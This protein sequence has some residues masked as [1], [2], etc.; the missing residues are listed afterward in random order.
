MFR[1]LFDAADFGKLTSFFSLQYL[2]LFLPAV[3]LFYSLTP[4]RGKKYTLLLASLVF[5]FLI[6]RRF[7]VY[8]LATI[9][10]VWLFGLWLARLHARRDAEVKAAE[11]PQRKAIKRVWLIRSRFVLGL[12]AVFH[13][14]LLLTLKYSGFFVENVN[15]FFGLQFPVP[16]FVIPIG[17]SFFTLQAVSYLFD[18]YRGTLEADRNLLRLALFISFFPQIVEGPIC[19]YSQTAQQLWE[20]KPI[21]WENLTLGLQRI[22]Y[23]LMKKL[24]VAD[25]LNAFIDGVFSDHTAF[26]GGIIAIAAVCYT[27]QLYMDFSGAMDAVTGTAQI[28]GITMPENF[29]QPFFS[30][31]ISEFWSRWHISLGTWFKDYIFYPVTMSKPMKNLTSAARKRIGNHFG[32]L[33]AGGIALFCVWFCNGLWHGAAWSFIF[34]GMYHFALILAGNI[35]APAAQWMHQKLQIR[36]ENKVFR[37]FQILRTCI[38]VVIGELFFRAEGLRIGLS[39]FTRMVTDFRFSSISAEMLKTLSIDPQDF[40]IVGI[41]LMIVLAVSL[42]KERGVQIR[43]VLQKQ[44]ILLR[45]AVI[46]ALI[47]YIITFGAYGVGYIPVNPMYANF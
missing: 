42:L 13:I 44:H 47:F 10:S 30:K 16:S 45:W 43:Q 39:M 29:R 31:T 23:G 5:F 22:L 40:L 27:I 26:P 34:F 36:P 41:T 20:A 8:L 9:L 37:G 33:L 19:R 24:V 46:Y 6:S 15:S 7:I 11:K 12:A 1:A 35:A 14:G 21:T 18:V 28:F 38:L 32:P 3:L 4:K 25:R 2:V 17:I